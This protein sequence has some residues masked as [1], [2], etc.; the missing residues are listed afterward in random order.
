M[1]WLQYSMVVN[2]R[3]HFIQLLP[4][5]WR[6]LSYE[7]VITYGGPN[8]RAMRRWT[9]DNIDVMIDNN[10]VTIDNNDVTIDNIHVTNS[11][12]R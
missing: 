6:Q 9:C 8:G 7:S 4:T 10:N 12:W 5:Q 1:F 11:M 2:L 3:T